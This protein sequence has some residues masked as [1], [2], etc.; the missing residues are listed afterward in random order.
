MVFTVCE[1]PL[2]ALPLGRWDGGR[3][4]GSMAWM[5]DDQSLLRPDNTLPLIFTGPPDLIPA[6]CRQVAA[7]ICRVDPSRH[8]LPCEQPSSTRCWV[9]VGPASAT[10]VQRS[11]SSGEWLMFAASDAALWQIV[12]T[13]RGNHIHARVGRGTHGGAGVNRPLDLV[14]T[15][16]RQ[17]SP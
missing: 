1:G 7:T 3:E 11:P 13:K 17:R 9:S 4:G 2:E 12:A 16:P 5:V 8:R 10:L 15:V 14:V 6:F